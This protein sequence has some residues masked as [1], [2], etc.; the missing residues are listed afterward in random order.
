MRLSLFARARRRPAASVAS[1]TGRPAKPTTPFTTTSASVTRSASS[2]TTSANGNASATAARS[3]ASAT[4]TV[5]GR[6]SRACSIKVATD[7][8]TPSAT[9]SYRS[10]SART[11]SSVCVPID[12]DD[13][14][15]ATRTVLIG[16][17]CQRYAAATRPGHPSQSAAKPAPCRLCGVRRPPS[18]SSGR[19]VASECGTGGERRGT[20]T[21]T[22]RQRSEPEGAAKAKRRPVP[23]HQASPTNVTAGRARSLAACSTPRGA[24]TGTRRI[25]RGCRR[26]QEGSCRSP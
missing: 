14:A 10:R 7:E 19:L 20:A 11:T 22:R 16:S 25:D 24:R 26:A 8:P 3:E 1:V 17:V 9:T 21:A 23:T 15:M 4:A 12:P 13:P 18:R 6:N 5:F 2:G